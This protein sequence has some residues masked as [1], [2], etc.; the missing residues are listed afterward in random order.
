[1]ADP[2]APGDGGIESVSLIQKATHFLQ[3]SR[4]RNPGVFVRQITSIAPNLHF[5]Q[6]LIRRS[7]HHE[8]ISVVQK[9]PLLWCC[10]N[11]STKATLQD[12]TH[13]SRSCLPDRTYYTD[14]RVS[15]IASA[16]GA[17]PAPPENLADRAADEPLFHSESPAMPSRFPGMD[18]FLESLETALSAA[19][20]TH[21]SSVS[22][23]PCPA[24]P[25]GGWV[26]IERSQSWTCV[27]KR[28]AVASGR[29]SK[30]HR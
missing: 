29:T 3:T 10:R 27:R 22:P 21:S 6:G 30:D 16:V 1:M 8:S 23:T 2:G 13:F 15:M 24:E 28:K 4:R 7:N 20:E 18:P 26:W 12:V 5:I 14:A 19:T 25:G 9:L 11:E 17:S